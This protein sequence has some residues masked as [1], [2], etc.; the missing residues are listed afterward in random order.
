MFLFEWYFGF[1]PLMRFLIALVPLGI[2][3]VMFLNGT[4]W[5]WGWIVGAVMLCC[6]L[7]SRGEKSEWGDW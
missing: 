3:T 4:I 1:P 7:P 6:A 2:S 5:P